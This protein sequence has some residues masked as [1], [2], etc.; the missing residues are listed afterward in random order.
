L[1]QVTGRPVEV[2][3]KPDFTE[4]DVDELQARFYGELQRTV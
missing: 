3:C 2:T 1:A 4:A